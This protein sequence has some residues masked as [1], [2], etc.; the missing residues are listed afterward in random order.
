MFKNSPSIF[1]CS[2][3]CFL[4]YFSFSYL[5]WLHLAEIVLQAWPFYSMYLIFIFCLYV[6]F[7]V[8]NR[9]RFELIA[10]FQLCL[11]VQGSFSM[12][13]EAVRF[14][15]EYNGKLWRSGDTWDKRV[16]GSEKQKGDQPEALIVIHARGGKS[17]HQAQSQRSVS[18]SNVVW[19]GQLNQLDKIW[20]KTHF[21]KYF[22]SFFFFFFGWSS[23]YR[24]YTFLGL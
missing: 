2:F 15:Y 19:F 12:W 1:R 3:C 16:W 20:R 8:F 10:F 13:L 21:L 18:G 23:S 24:L 9:S 7:R 17:L 14:Y 22:Q 11:E 5:K 4:L 6:D